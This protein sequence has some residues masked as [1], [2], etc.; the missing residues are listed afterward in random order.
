MPRFT[1]ALGLALA[2]GLAGLGAAELKGVNL[3]THVS[4]PKVT[5][6]DLGGKV[7]IFE[8]WGVN[9]PPCR[10]N[11]PHI[12][13]LAA[14]ADPEQLVVLA[15]H[16]QGPGRTAAVWKECGGTDKPTVIEAGDLPGSNVTGIPRIFVFD[17]TGKQVFDGSPGQ[18]DDAMIKKLLDA[19]P[20]PLVKA[21]SYKA[22]AGEA[23]AL[24]N[25]DRPVGSVLKALRTKAEKGKPEAQLEAQQLLEGVK[26]YAD[27][28]YAGI[29][30]DR[31]TDPVSAWLRVQRLALVLKGDEWGKPFEDL[32][33]ELKADK[34][35]MDEL[36]AADGLAAIKAQATK[37]GLDRGQLPPSRKN[38]A[39]AIGQAIDQLGKKY[40]GT[41][42]AKEAEALKAE[43]AR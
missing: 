26:S 27:R 21:G 33:K 2:A 38:E 16:C 8:Y 35:F 18:V 1:L 41:R 40:P 11:I 42:A 23:A 34:P 15:N 4:G 43:W 7:V 29:T 17:H 24:K 3:G 9:C 20:G 39:Q 32:V 6:D 5:L 12:S 36:K 13:E 19:A 31:S 28:Q 30:A 37:I 22:C 25:S 14:L 10:A